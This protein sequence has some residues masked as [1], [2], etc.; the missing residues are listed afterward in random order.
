MAGGFGGAGVL[1]DRAQQY[2]YNTNRYLV[3][4]CIVAALGGSLF[5]YDLG[6]SGRSLFSWLYN[7]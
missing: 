1:H 4:S 6:V 5:G 3:F 7:F 2:E